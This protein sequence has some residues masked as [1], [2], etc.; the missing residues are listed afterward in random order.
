MISLRPYQID[1]IRRA[2][3]SIAEGNKSIIIQG[4]C[5]IGKTIISSGICEGALLK[6]KKVLFLAP[7]RELIFQ[8]INRFADY[9]LGDETAI[10]MAGEKPDNSKPIQVASVWTYARRIKLKNP[11]HRWFH[12]TDIIILDEC[13]G[14]LAPTYTKILDRYNGNAVKIGLSATPSRSDG[15]GLG[16]IY[17]KIISAIGIKELT[18]DGYLVPVTHYGTKE[19]PDIKGLKTKMGD[20][21]K[22]EA[23]KRINKDFLVGEIYDNWARL[24]SSRQTIIFAQGVKHSKYIRDVFERRGV[25]IRH[26]DA[27]TPDD[28]RADI[29]HQFENGDIQVITNVGILDQGYDCP[30]VSCIVLAVI[31]KHI[32]RFLQMGGR[33]LRP[34]PEK[35]DAIIIDHGMNI[36][37][38]GFITD[39]YNWE[40]SNKDKAWKKKKP[41]KKEAKI[42]ECS[43]CRAMHSGHTC[44]QCGHK[45]ADWGKK[46]ET[47]DDDLQEIT[48]NGKKKKVFTM[49]EK[50]KFY[51]QLEYERR[52]KGYAPGWIYHKYLAKFGVVPHHSLE[53]LPPV[54]PDAGFFNWI[55]YQNIKWAKSKSN[56]RNQVAA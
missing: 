23:E 10:L 18:K 45:I 54:Q 6:G 30:A 38:L 20:F 49:E 56:P 47:T 25:P 12:D 43:E 32:G 26:I 17:D 7:R 40:L 14:S 35:K 42:F 15:R 36:N 28:E 27:H 19:K 46:I 44:P 4:T 2:R 52:M 16:Q 33:C 11:E 9:G 8:A 34:Y 29:L 13:H 39:E 51:G 41:R 5:G 1:V 24:A 50:R 48:K 22:A 55:K 53:N 37:R 21:D 3:E 31:T